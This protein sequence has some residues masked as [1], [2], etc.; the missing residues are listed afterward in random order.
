MTPLGLLHARRFAAF[1]WAQFLGAFNDDLF[2]DALVVLATFRA[3][4]VLGPPA[5]RVVAIAGGVSTLLFV[6][7]SASAGPMMGFGAVAIAARVLG[8]RFLGR[9]G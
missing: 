7:F 6:L 3:L 2:R 4:S 8:P 9:L 1:F 5:D